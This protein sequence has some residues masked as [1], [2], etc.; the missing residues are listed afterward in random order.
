MVGTVVSVIIVIWKLMRE[1]I[2][3]ISLGVLSYHSV[4]SSRRAGVFVFSCVLTTSS[5]AHTCGP[6]ILETLDPP[7]NICYYWKIRIHVAT[8]SM[9]HH[10]HRVHRLHQ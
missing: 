7:C 4:L 5:R 1:T 10:S 8:P 6:E 2:H 9:L 3:A